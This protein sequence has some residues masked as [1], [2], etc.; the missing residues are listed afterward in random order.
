[1]QVP[2]V[3]SW[4]YPKFVFPCDVLLNQNRKSWY[5]LQQVTFEASQNVSAALQEG[6][7]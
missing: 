7:G 2:C 1:M 5:S 4:V 6:L 3:G